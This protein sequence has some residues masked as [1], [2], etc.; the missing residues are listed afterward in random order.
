[1]LSSFLMYL[2]IILLSVCSML[3]FAENVF[4]HYLKKTR[5]PLTS[6]MTQ[7]SLLIFVTLVGFVFSIL[8]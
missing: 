6:V 8:K 5:F 7:I 4:P 3:I 1:M 2:V